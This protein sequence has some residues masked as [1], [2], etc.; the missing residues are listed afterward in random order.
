MIIQSTI[1]D[2]WRAI[3]WAD[4]TDEEIIAMLDA[5][6]AGKIDIHDYWHV[7]DERVISLFA[8]PSGRVSETHVAQD[9]TM[10]LMNR[11]GKELVEPINGISECAFIVG[12]KDTLLETGYMN[13][14]NT[15]SIAWYN[16]KRR[17]WCYYDYR[18]SFPT[19]IQPIF[20]QFRNNTASG[21]GSEISHSLDWF[22][23]PSAKEAYGQSGSGM[24]NPDA[25]ASLSQFEYYSTSKNRKKTLPWWTRSRYNSTSTIRMLLISANGSSLQ[26]H[27]MD[28]ATSQGFAPFG[29]I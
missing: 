25:E 18:F 3:T 14:T 23:L 8:I 26:F 12:Q 28:N 4:G 7:G 22:A 15:D 9:I 27:V 11:G 2:P 16:C 10:V 21:G 24:Y 1:H 5:H 6:Y 17:W 19:T 29:V 13:D 20:K